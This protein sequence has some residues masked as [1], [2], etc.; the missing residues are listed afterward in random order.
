MKFNDQLWHLT[1]SHSRFVWRGMRMHWWRYTWIYLYVYTDSWIGEKEGPIMRAQTGTQKEQTTTRQAP[2]HE[3]VLGNKTKF[4]R[5]IKSQDATSSLFYY[6]RLSLRAA[7]L[8]L[9][10]QEHLHT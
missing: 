5:I 10:E 6:P 3:S 4:Y 1:A 8:I 7:L 2:R 9:M